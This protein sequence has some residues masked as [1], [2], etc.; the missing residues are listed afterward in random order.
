[1]SAAAS[2]SAIVRACHH[3]AEK[4]YAPSTDGNVSVRTDARS[5]LI[6][7]SGSRFS[8]LKTS[9]LVAVRFDGT[10]RTRRKRPSSEMALHRAL[11]EADRT[12][13]AVVHAHPPYA[14]AFAASGTRLTPNVLPE[15]ILDLGDI[16]LVRYA[17]PSSD[18]LGALVARH[19]GTCTAALL[20]NHGAVAWGS[21]LSEAV[22][23]MEKLE[24]AASVELFARFLG[25]ARQLSHEQV[26][27]LRSLHPLSRWAK[28]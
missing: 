11:Y 5:M 4:G 17:M 12:I 23:R 9:D 14:T 1:M 21:T 2:P 18:E 15:V 7:A 16:P 10:S 24:H 27:T 22:R 26:A 28:P 19:A 6:T 25:G 3:L 8:D 20:A 13:G